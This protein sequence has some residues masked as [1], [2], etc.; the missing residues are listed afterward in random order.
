MRVLVACEF[1]GTIRDAIKN[2]HP[3]YDV[4]S[5]DLLPSE[6]PGDHYQG[7]VFDIL[8]FEAHEDYQG[9]WYEDNWDLI[10]AHPP[11]QHIAVS[12]ARWFPE[13]RKDGRQQA[14][15]DFFMM[16]TRVGVQRVAI[17]NPIGIM[18]RIYRKPDQIIQPFH[19][20]DSCQKATC[21]WL[22]GLPLL[23]PTDVVDRGMVY[24]DPRGNPHGGVFTIMAKKEYSPL[25]LLPRNKERWKIRSRTFK[26][27]ANA[28]ATQW[29]SI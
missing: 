9:W 16:F 2:E 28:I 20:G 5:C 23:K 17:E 18:S 13:K 12:G 7:D 11:C 27:I 19:Y 10:V 4:R 25:M 15:I 29:C 6:T 22:K 24:V 14:G 8:P 3:D 26:G 21:L 1:S